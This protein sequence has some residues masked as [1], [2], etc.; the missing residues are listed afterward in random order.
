[1]VVALLMFF[2]VGAIL[3]AVDLVALAAGRKHPDAP[4]DAHGHAW[5][6]PGWLPPVAGVAV[7]L[8][9]MGW[10]VWFIIHHAVTAGVLGL[11]SEDLA[12]AAW[13][14]FA[15]AKA[16][17]RVMLDAQFA[18]RPTTAWHDAAMGGKLCVAAPVLLL[19]GGV[20][21]L[22]WLTGRWAASAVAGRR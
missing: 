17:G 14:W 9:V 1:V 3:A 11:V 8:A 10:P 18:G 20:P 6:V 19:G 5:A 4:R 13:A 2:P 22:G 12:G 21:A 7:G 15:M 16:E